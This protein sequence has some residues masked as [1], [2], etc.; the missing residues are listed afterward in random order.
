[1]WCNFIIYIQRNTLFQLNSCSII[2]IFFTFT[3]GTFI[4][5]RF[6]EN[7]LRFGVPVVVD[8]K[9]LYYSHQMAIVVI[10]IIKKH[11]LS[12]GGKINDVNEKNNFGIVLLILSKRDLQKKNESYLHLRTT[13]M[14][15][16]IFFSPFHKLHNFWNRIAKFKNRQDRS[17]VKHRLRVLNFTM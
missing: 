13:V 17:Q 5:A 9:I 2:F 4:F 12:A 3:S 10:C 11:R 1:M 14:K 15:T 6:Y 16:P 8:L 7:L